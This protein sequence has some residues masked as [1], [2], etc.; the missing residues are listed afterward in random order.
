VNNTT[1]TSADLEL[2]HHAKEILRQ[3]YRPD[4]HLVGAAIRARS[5]QVI[6]GVHI[7]AN[8][9]RVTICGEAVAIGRAITEGINELDTI[10]AVRR[11]DADPDVF[12]V[13][14]PCGMCREMINDYIPNGF[15]I[16][17]ENDELKKVPAGDL[18]PGK[19]ARESGV[20]A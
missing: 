5:G 12:Y 7:E 15:C 17:V 6:T 11:D 16:C 9:G 20:K 19:Y 1:V 8:V 14:S 2:I 13:V 18:L 10:V 3:R 4:H